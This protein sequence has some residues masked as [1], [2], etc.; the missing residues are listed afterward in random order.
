M[1]KT[2]IERVICMRLNAGLFKGFWAEALS[3]TC[4]VINRSPHASL[5]GKV[6]EEVW[7]GN[8][9]NYNLLRTFGC[10]AY[11][12][13]PSDERSKLDLKSKRCIFIGY[14]KGG[15]GFKFWD[16]VSRKVVLSRDAVFDEDFLLKDSVMTE[17]PMPN[18]DTLRSN[19]IPLNSE[20]IQVNKGKES[21][22][23][24][25][26]EHDDSHAQSSGVQEYLLGR[27]KDGRP[28]KPPEIYGFEDMASV[29]LHIS[30]GDPC[31]FQDAINNPEKEQWMGVIME[32]MESL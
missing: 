7:T 21:C 6:V 13:V 9:I 32:E 31:S 1:N 11:V 28:I 29:A 24:S 27:D 14:T 17:V 5:D 16:P 15:K 4:Y 20:T 12:H 22:T 26:Q 8:L 23:S 2:L 18:G 10:P 19:M 30:S 3:M 25:S